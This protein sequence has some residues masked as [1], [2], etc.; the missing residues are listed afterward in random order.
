MSLEAFA[1]ANSLY[2]HFCLLALFRPFCHVKS[3]DLLPA[4]ICLESADSILT[5]AKVCGQLDGFHILCFVPIFVYAAAKAEVDI[6][7]GL[8]ELTSRCAGSSVASL[9]MTR[10]DSTASDAT[11]TGGSSSELSG[12]SRAA[13][14]SLTD[15]ALELLVELSDLYP[16]ARKAASELQGSM[17]R[18]ASAL[19]W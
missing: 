7:S 2:Y 6:T 19:G 13:I 16:S 11:A 17:S 3:E 9:S 18:R 5:L 4:R 14:R 1:D 8:E 15:R 12:N 10:G